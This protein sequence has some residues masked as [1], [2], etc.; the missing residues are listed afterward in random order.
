MKRKRKACVTI[1][2]RRHCLIKFIAIGGCKF[3]VF[4]AKDY[5]TSWVVYCKIRG[6]LRINPFMPLPASTTVIAYGDQ[7]V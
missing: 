4:T 5:M 7:K 6:W 1:A 3:S 2:K